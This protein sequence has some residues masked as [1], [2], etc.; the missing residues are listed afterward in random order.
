MM[1]KHNKNITIFTML[2]RLFPQVVS[3]SPMLYIFN[4]ILFILD[5]ASFA[6]SLFFMQ[7]LFDRVT[8]LADNTGT[9]REAIFALIFLASIKILEQIIS[10]LDNFIGETYDP[11]VYGK[12]THMV[13]EKMAKINPICFENQNLLNDINKSYSGI[14]VAIN[15]INTITDT[16]TLYIPHF[17][18]ISVYLFYLKPSLVLVL[19]FIFLPV[20]FTQ[21]INVKIYNKLEDSS[22]PLRRKSEYYSRCLT[23]REYIKE[24][25]M[26][27]ACPYFIKL[28]KETLIQMNELKLKADIRANLIELSTKLVSIAGYLGVLWML[29]DALMKQEISVGAFATVFASVGSMFEMMEGLVCGRFGYYAKNFGKVQNYLRFLDLPERDDNKN[30]EIE[31]NERNPRENKNHEITLKRDIVLKNVTFSYPLSSNNAVEDISLKIN[32]GETI[33][34]VGENGSGKSTLVRLITGLYLP[35]EG[36]VF[37]NNKSTH[38]LTTKELFK[39]ISGVFQNYQRYQ[40]SLKDNIVISEIISNEELELGKQEKLDKSIKQ[41]GIELESEI[42]T[43]GYDTMLSREFDGIDLS[44]GQWQKVSIARGFYR[45]HDVIIL[46][47]PTAS[48][49]PM[50]E[51]KTYERFS[52]ISK[53]KTSIIV[54]HRLASVKFADRII[55]MKDGKVMGMGT[56]DILLNTCPIYSKMWESQS[57]YYT[58]NN[59]LA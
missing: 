14:G 32:E 22:A 58:N 9:L 18:F 48:I 4:C 13:N 35:K 2:Y 10:G 20:F 5:G 1:K 44:G 19:L 45:S 21:F 28:F 46:D 7:L 8:N 52:E 55:V 54:T 6:V 31:I 47:E 34:I 51:I 36:S 29:F 59:L 30:V 53:N 41:S 26:L 42:F 25:R 23:D 33:A 12:L 39:G 11:K 16:V 57:Q 27:G 40:L 24:T 49:D 37:H 15:F 38:D 17:L 43:K 56:H 3:V 50:E